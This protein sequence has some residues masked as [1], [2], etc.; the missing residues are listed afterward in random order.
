MD[1]KADLANIHQVVGVDMGINFVAT[2][3]DSNSDTTFF[4]G[5]PI[6]HKRAKYKQLRKELQQKQTPSA[7]RKLKQIGQREN[8]WMQDVNHCISKA[9][10]KTYGQDTLF[11]VEDLTG[12]RAATEKVRVKGRYQ[13]VSWSFY[14]LR[15]KIEYKALKAQAKV[16]AIDPTYTSQTCPKC[17]HTEKANRHKKTHT[18]CCKTC[19]YTSNDDRI[20][21]MN[22][23]RKGIEYL[24]EE[25]ART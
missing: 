3:Y 14:D 9:L 8:R 12:V 25:T 21:A 20:G 2:S 19:R 18:F 23:Q 22:L 10:V 24:V 6:K 11:V 7:R 17:E 15:Q 13:M 4:N 5:R 16:I 1:E